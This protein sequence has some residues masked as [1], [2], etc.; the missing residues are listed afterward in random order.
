MANWKNFDAL[1]SYE[2]LLKLKDKV[3]LTEVMAGEAGERRVSKY[4]VPMSS[5]LCFSYAAKQVD[6]TV[7]D[8]L[9]AL[10]EE[11]QLVDKYEEL[12]RGEGPQG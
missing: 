9:S 6:D 2:K 1:D 10:A 4:C 7:L 3:D 8:A 11:A 5:G 12:L